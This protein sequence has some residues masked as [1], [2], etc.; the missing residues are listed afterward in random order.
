M[1]SIDKE[2]GMIKEWA[3]KNESRIKEQDKDSFWDTYDS[4]GDIV[5]Y[6]F[7]TVTELKKM[8]GE[9]LVGCDDVILPLAVAAFKKKEW[10]SPNS[11]INNDKTGSGDF[12]IPEFIYV[13]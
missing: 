10:S 13:F 6:E 7:K 8:F 9:T 3:V 12:T 1:S 4:V 5:E 11:E 2:K